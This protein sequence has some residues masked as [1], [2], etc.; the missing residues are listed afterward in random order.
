VRYDD[1]APWPTE[2]DGDGPSL[3]LLDPS[4]DNALATSW[5]ASIAPHGTPGEANSLTEPLDASDA[6][7]APAELVL[8][9]ATPNP[10]NPTTR[11]RLGIDARAKT[12]LSVFD[13]AGREV[14]R[15]VDGALD[16]GWY[17]VQWRADGVASGVYFARLQSGSR[18]RVQKLLLTK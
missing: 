18:G 7:A 2:P 6:P 8:A 14:A 15:L 12:T 3:E 10:F 4:L 16:P 5:A 17:E 13:V 11:I 9:P 1:V